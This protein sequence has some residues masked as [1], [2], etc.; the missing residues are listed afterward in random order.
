[1]YCAEYKTRWFTESN[2]RETW[3]VREGCSK[4]MHFELWTDDKRILPKHLGKVHSQAEEQQVQRLWGVA[5]R[6]KCQHCWSRVLQE[7]RDGDTCPQIITV[8][9]PREVRCQEAFEKV[10]PNVIYRSCIIKIS[11]WNLHDI[12]NQCHT[13]EF[14]FKKY[15]EYAV[16]WL[17]HLSMWLCGLDPRWQLHN[18]LL[19]SLWNSITAPW[20]NCR[21]RA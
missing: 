18:I 19:T 17:S 16:C 1:M 2:W 4:D 12:I 20:C 11:T 13:N 15:E 8:I 5:K 21:I 9:L 3:V 10:K 7:N 6:P 14:K